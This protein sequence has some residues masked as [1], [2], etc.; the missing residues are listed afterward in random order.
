MRLELN[1]HSDISGQLSDIPDGAQTAFSE[2]AL[3][4]Y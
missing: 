2:E 4:R 1:K 3:L